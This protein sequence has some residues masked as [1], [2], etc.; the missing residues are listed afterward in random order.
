MSPSELALLCD[1][2]STD[3][4]LSAALRALGER[5]GDAAQVASLAERLAPRLAA[6]SAAAPAASVLLGAK[7][8]ALLLCLGGIGA[9]GAHATWRIARPD[10]VPAVAAP[11]A[12]FAPPAR[13]RLVITPAPAA[14]AP[15]VALPEPAVQTLRPR[16]A[17]PTPSATPDPDAELS[18]LQRAQSALEHAPAAAL[19]LAGE[20]ARR[21][22][23]G[24]LVQEREIIAL[25]SLLRLKRRAAAVARAERFV[26]R[27]PDSPHTRRVRALLERSTTTIAPGGSDS[28]AEP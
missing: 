14:A 8:I 22:S 1:D 13:A 2:P 21:F 10:E 9:W 23:S 6:P 16:V 28:S 25:E 3:P 12:A 4:E 17:R 11:P 7:P 5:S 24:V 15:P 26:Q 20:H 18:L 27:F 19:E